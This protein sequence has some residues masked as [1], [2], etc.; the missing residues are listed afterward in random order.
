MSLKL[1]RSTGYSSILSA[2]ETRVATH[3]GWV[4][5][6]TSLWAGFASNQALW[7]AVS[8]GGGMGQALVT[9][10]FMAA[11]GAFVLS[12]LGWH[13]TLKPAAVLVLFVAALAASNTSGPAMPMDGA[14]LPSLNLPSYAGLLRWQVWA[15]LAVLALIPAIGVCKTQVRRLP[16]NE[17]LGVNMM[18]LTLAGASLALSGFV[19]FSGFL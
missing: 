1:F 4:I 12:V 9:G 16:G 7:R 8:G 3:P 18:G 2:G 13:K 15:G 5:L 14:S 11:A 6:C 17:Q 19:L 10:A